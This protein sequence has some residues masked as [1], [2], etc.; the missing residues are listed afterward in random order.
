VKN[1]TVW[2]K[3]G[4]RVANTSNAINLDPVVFCMMVP[5][6]LEM[7]NQCYKTFFTSQL[8]LQIAILRLPM[9]VVVNGVEK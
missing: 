5:D 1:L 8:Q 7:R 3:Y 4:L 2:N 6:L 9:L